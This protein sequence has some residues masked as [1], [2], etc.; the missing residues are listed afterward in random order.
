[1]V[2]VVVRRD[3]DV[4][5]A[6]SGRERMLGRVDAPRAR[7]VAEHVDDLVTELDLLV[8]REV[9]GEEGVVDL[10][11]VKG[12]DQIDELGL[13]LV[14][15]ARDL[16]GLHLRLEVVEEDV[17]GLVTA[18]EAVDVAAAQLDL[19]LHDGEE[20]V[21]VRG[22]LGLEP[23]RRGLGGRP[24]HLAAK[25]RGHL[26]GLPVV[27]ARGADRRRLPRIGIERVEARLELVD[28]PADLGV[29]EPLVL[30]PLEQRHVRTAPDEAGGG[31]DRPLVPGEEVRER[32]ERRTVGEARVES[33]ERVG[34]WAPA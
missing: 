13:D 1:M 33:F 5:D 7:A 27:P 18:L 15:D 30:E 2:R 20:E 17:V 16:G 8:D 31:H 29:D 34:H 23:D 19:P 22:R 10:A 32:I 21:E 24:R 26:D 14:E 9:A 28:Q 4:V 3:A 12:R 25:L 6:G 11:P